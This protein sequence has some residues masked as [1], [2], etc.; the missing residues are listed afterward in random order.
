MTW[1][2]ARQQFPNRW[3]IFEVIRGHQEAGQWSVDELAILESDKAAA[4]VFRRYSE[5]Q[6]TYPSREL[7]F[8]HTSQISIICD[9][10]ISSR[11]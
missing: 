4:S 8:F 2:E 3:L 6:R 9:A 5:L 11:R 1:S 7:G 10:H